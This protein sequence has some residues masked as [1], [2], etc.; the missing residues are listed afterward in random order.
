MRKFVV[1]KQLRRR[2]RSRSLVGQVLLT[3]VGSFPP[4]DDCGKH[5]VGMD[6]WQSLL[7]WFEFAEG[8]AGFRGAPARLTSTPPPQL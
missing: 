7:D 1:E 2:A 5:L 3:A 6:R 4:K 8:Y